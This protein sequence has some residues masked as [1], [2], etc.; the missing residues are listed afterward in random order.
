MFN[1]TAFNFSA[2]RIS[3]ADKPSRRIAI[4][5]GILGQNPP[6]LWLFCDFSGTVQF[7]N[8]NIHN[9]LK[10]ARLSFP[11]YYI[12]EAHARV[13][14]V[15]SL[16][17]SWSATLKLL[18]ILLYRSGRSSWIFTIVIRP[19]WLCACATNCYSASDVR[20]SVDCSSRGTRWGWCSW[21]AVDLHGR[22]PPPIS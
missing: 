22:P 15:Y 17:A 2:L 13:G 6:T 11:D 20:A 19:N 14:G 8:I 10:S 18:C 7:S 9:G 1:C 4:R 21:F 12:A 5:W 3:L 16:Q